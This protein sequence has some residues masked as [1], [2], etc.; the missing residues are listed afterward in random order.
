MTLFKA[1][2]IAF[3]RFSAIPMP[4]FQWRDTEKS[5]SMMFFPLVGA[6]TGA[7]CLLVYNLSMALSFPDM[8]AAFLIASLPVIITGGIHLDGY[9]DV[10]DAICSYKDKKQKLEILKDPHIGAFAVINLVKL[11]LIYTAALLILIGDGNREFFYAFCCSFVVSRSLSVIAL[12]SMKMAKN[13]GT[14]YES[15]AEANDKK[16]LVFIVSILWIIIAAGIMFFYT[17]AGGVFSVAAAVIS[18]IGCRRKAYNNFGGIT[19]DVAGYFVVVCEVNMPV[20]LV[21]VSKLLA[22]IQRFLA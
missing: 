14:L 12:L 11:T 17:P 8:A 20:V 1:C 10:T 5:L 4:Q 21:T 19:G 18:L 3:L 22:C 16:S 7:V 13:D 9:M 6:V 15:Q 2:A